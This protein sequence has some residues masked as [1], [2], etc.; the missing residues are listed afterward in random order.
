MFYQKPARYFDGKRPRL[1]PRNPPIAPPEAAPIKADSIPLKK[2][3]KSPPKTA[4]M[5]TQRK[6]R[7]PPRRQTIIP[8]SAP[9]R[10]M[11]MIQNGPPIKNPII[12]PVI[13]VTAMPGRET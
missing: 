9:T 4:P 13:P 1:T 6:N 5:M 3:A 10:A 12:P 11:R 2:I 7:C 8:K